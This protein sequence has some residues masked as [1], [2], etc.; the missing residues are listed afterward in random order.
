MEHFLSCVWVHLTQLIQMQTMKLHVW[1]LDFWVI[2]KI[3]YNFYFSLCILEDPSL[4]EPGDDC[5]IQLSLENGETKSFVN[6]DIYEYV[7]RVKLPEYVSCDRCVLRWTYRTG[8]LW[9]YVK[10]SNR[11]LK[12][13]RKVSQLTV[14]L[15]SLRN[16]NILLV[17]TYND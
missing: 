2:S 8:E 11:I 12:I 10:I 9:K 5:F 16:L 17:Y 14:Q 7:D 4:P 13:L 6:A 1:V 3:H 15:I